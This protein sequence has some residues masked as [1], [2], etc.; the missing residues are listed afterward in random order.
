MFTSP[1]LKGTEGIL[2]VTEVYLD[3]LKYKELELTFKDGC[4]TDYTCK[5]F[6]NEADNKN[7][8]MKMYFTGMILYLSASLQSE[9]TLPPT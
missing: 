4:V 3:N 7:I 9:Q 2:H 6:D 5:N 8:F 1:E